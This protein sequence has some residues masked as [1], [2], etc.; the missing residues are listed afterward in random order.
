MRQGKLSDMVSNAKKA[1]API[2]ANVT[3]DLSHLDTVETDGDSDDEIDVHKYTCVFWPKTGKGAAEAGSFVVTSPFLYFIGS[4]DSKFKWMWED[5]SVKLTTSLGAI[6]NGITVCYQPGK[7][8]AETTSYKFTLPPP[9]R[10]K[11]FACMTKFA[12][13]DNRG[14]KERRKEPSDEIFEKKNMDITLKKYMKGISINDFNESFL[15]RR[16]GPD[17]TPIYEEF[18][19]LDGRQNVQVSDFVTAEDGKEFVGDWCGEKY[20]RKRTIT[21]TFNKHG[22][23]GNGTVTQYVRMEGDNKLVIQGTTAVTGPP[24]SDHMTIH[25]RVI[26]NV[27]D[28]ENVLVL[29]GI[30]IEFVKSTMLEGKIRAIA[31]AEGTKT[32]L[33]LYELGK[34][35]YFDHLGA[36]SVTQAVDRGIEDSAQLA[37][38]V[39]FYGFPAFF[40]GLLALFYQLTAL[41]YQLMAD[42]AGKPRQPGKIKQ[43]TVYKDINNGQ[44]KLNKIAEI[45][46]EMDDETLTNKEKKIRPHFKVVH[47]SLDKVLDQLQKPCQ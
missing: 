37:K 21:Y 2:D 13:V 11:A 20:Q 28:E 1:V 12:S 19:I 6:P 47:Q 10:T 33:Q 38:V 25:H 44:E 8:G 29:A 14:G 45:A 16:K 36:E 30:F 40:A 32:H 26:V 24:Y 35:Y 5:I 22:Y 4:R 42:M 18:L 46:N 27:V 34:T 39:P 41:F 9:I 3:E 43:G 17:N 31:M 15:E 7:D 23:N